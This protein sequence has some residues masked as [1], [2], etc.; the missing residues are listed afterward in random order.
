MFCCHEYHLCDVI[1]FWVYGSPVD[2][3]TQGYG[4]TGMEVLRLILLIKFSK[5]NN[6]V[7]MGYS[8]GISWSE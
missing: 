7:Q 4:Y 3:M 2:D 6:K 5:V 1:L 8:F